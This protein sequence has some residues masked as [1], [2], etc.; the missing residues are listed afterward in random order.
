MRNHDPSRPDELNQDALLLA[1][2]SNGGDPKIAPVKIV[3]GMVEPLQLSEKDEKTYEELI[4]Y[5]IKRDLPNSE[6]IYP[7]P[8]VRTL[9]ETGD[10]EFEIV[11][12]TIERVKGG[13]KVS[14]TKFPE[15]IEAEF[16]KM[17]DPSSSEPSTR[18]TQEE[19]KEIVLGGIRF[20]T[21]FP[22]EDPD[23]VWDG[24]PFWEIAGEPGEPNNLFCDKVLEELQ[25][26]EPSSSKLHSDQ[27]SENPKELF[28][29]FAVVPGSAFDQLLHKRYKKNQPS[30][31][32][33]V[34]RRLCKKN[35]K[36]PVSI[37]E[38]KK[39]KTSAGS[40]SKPQN[41]PKKTP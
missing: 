5:A 16:E 13:I 6:E 38:R 9:R 26:E 10:G 39:G 23:H 4:D 31:F 33:T 8:L 37:Y 7:Y 40:H 29:R 22:S 14:P 21:W 25:K 15:W 18:E 28:S 24:L 30:L 2:I 3:D 1:Y 19:S 17:S 12:A 36:P 35:G 41:D 32:L 20:K 34:S 27:T 11:P